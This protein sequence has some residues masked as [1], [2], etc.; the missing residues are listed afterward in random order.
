MKPQQRARA[1][2]LIAACLAAWCSVISHRSQAEP[3]ITFALDASSGRVAYYIDDPDQQHPYTGAQMREKRATWQARGR[4][5][6][7][8]ELLILSDAQAM[9]ALRRLREGKAA[10]DPDAAYLEEITGSRQ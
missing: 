8:G 10:I 7:V 5:P 6:T 1:E 4:N 9:A 3:V 2:A